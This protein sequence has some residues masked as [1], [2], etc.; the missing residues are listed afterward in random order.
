[1]SLFEFNPF[2]ASEELTPSQ[3]RGSKMMA[4]LRVLLRPMKWLSDLF[5]EDFIL[6]T[7]SEYYDNAKT[8][9]KGNRV[10]W[11]DRG[12]YELKVSSS[13]GVNPTG[14]TLSAINWFKIL[15]DFIG[16]DEIYKTTG[17]LIVAEYTINRWFNITSAPYIYFEELTGTPQ[18]TLICYVP[19]LKV[20]NLGDTSNAQL[21]ALRR[22]T[23]RCFL[24]NI[25]VS[26]TTY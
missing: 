22:F 25:V 3:L 13:V 24:G 23:D 16:I 14:E 18:T 9:V 19:I 2:R 6:G 7:N 20:T 10:I 26:I 17:Q 4:W 21:S 8:Y 1:M 12:V 15:N 5:T 11:E